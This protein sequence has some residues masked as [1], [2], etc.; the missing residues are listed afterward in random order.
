MRLP[1]PLGILNVFGFL[2]FA[3]FAWVQ[4]NDIDPAVY[5]RPS[6][7]DAWL[8]LL[9]YAVIAILFVLAL[10]RPVAKWV[11]LVAALAY[12]VEMGRTV[13]GLWKNLF[14]ELAFTM[15]QSSMSATD[16]RAE[17]TR[18]FFGALIALAGVGV[19]WWEQRKFDKDRRSG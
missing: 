7:I 2:L 17:L 19:L 6:V 10:I 12:F 14:G 1:I 3:A 11:L 8:W 13:P 15:T 4:H 9:F 16:P 18:E 5:D